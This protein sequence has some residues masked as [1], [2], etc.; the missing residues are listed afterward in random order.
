M[1]KQVLVSVDRGETRVAL[2]EATGT[3]AR[4]GAARRSAQAARTRPRATA[5][6]SSTSSAAA[7][8]R[9]SATSTRARSTTSCRPRGRVRR[10]RPREERL[11]A[12]RRDRAAGRRDRRAAAAAAAAASKITDLLKPGQEVV[13]Q[14][15]KDPLKTKGAR[16]SMELTIAGRYMV[17]APTGEGVGVSQ[18]PRRQ[19]ARAPAQARPRA[20]TSTAA[21][22][23]SAPPRT[24]PSARTSSASCSTS[25][26]ST[27]CSQQARR[28]GARRRR[29]SSRRPTC[30]CASCATSSARDFERAIVDDEQAAPPARLV[31]HAHRARAGRPR[32]AL[33][34]SRRRCSRRYGVEEV[35]RRPDVAPR[36]PAQRR[37][38]DDRLRRGADGH[39]RQL[40]LVHRARQAGAPRGHD[41]EDEPRGGRG[42]RAPAAA[43][44]HRRDHRHRLHRHGARA[45]PRR[46]A[47]DAAQGARRG[48][49]QD[50]HGR[51]LASSAWS[52]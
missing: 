40:R 42:G 30:R 34:R 21:A 14:V 33:R 23:S 50:V 26:S 9:S 44:R 47:E 48:P 19:G 3:P 46:G 36:R 5:S 17:Y 12:R 28:G 4:E 1:K 18:A 22:R 41:H 37:L 49:H 39:R 10:H 31:L 7:A 27:R 6:P 52:R 13:V 43:A 29:W 15:V 35:D 32:R 16:L 38:P 24:A 25:S 51:D 45:Q 2:L 8:A 20:S 11:P